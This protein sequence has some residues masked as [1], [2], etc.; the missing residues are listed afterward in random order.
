MDLSNEEKQLVEQHRQKRAEEDANAWKPCELSSIS[1]A[2]KIKAFDKLY[3]MALE[4]FRQT[5]E[6]RYFDEDFYHYA[7]EEVMQF[8]G[9]D[10]Y[11]QAINK[12]IQFQMIA[13]ANQPV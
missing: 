1:D 7:G 13:I 10:V 6:D 12:W 11:D 9:K 2:T 5:K 3:K 4:T 8:L